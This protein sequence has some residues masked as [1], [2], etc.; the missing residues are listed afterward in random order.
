M[1]STGASASLKFQVEVINSQNKVGLVEY[2]LNEL[3]TNYQYF[4]QQALTTTFETFTLSGKY[5]GL[6]GAAVGYEIYEYKYKNGIESLALLKRGLFQT[7]RDEGVFQEMGVNRNNLGSGYTAGYFRDQKIQLVPGRQQL[8]I[9]CEN[10]GGLRSIYQV[11]GKYPDINY[12]MPAQNQKII[13]DNLA[14]LTPAPS[15]QNIPINYQVALEAF[16]TEQTLP[17]QSKLYTF[18]RT[19]ELTGEVKS[20]YNFTNL[21]VK[22]FTPGLVFENEATEQT[23]KVEAGNRFRIKVNIEI[24]ENVTTKDFD[25]GVIPSIPSLSNL[26]TGVRFIVS[27]SYKDTYFV[28][29]FSRIHP[30][31]WTATE[32]ENKRVPILIKFNRKDLPIPNAW[33]TL[34]LNYTTSLSGHLEP[35]NDTYYCLKNNND[36]MLERSDIK[37]GRNRIQWIL[38]YKDPSGGNS[39]VMSA[40]NSG[41]LGMN[42]DV[43]DYLEEISVTPMKISFS[44]NLTDQYYDQDNLPVLN[45]Q[46]DKSTKVVVKLNGITVKEEQGETENLPNIAFPSEALQE[47]MNELTVS[48]IEG[49]SG[50]TVRKVFSF[51]YDSLK[52]VAAFSSWTFTA[53]E[54]TINDLTVTVNEANYNNACLYYGAD[55]I[56]RYPEVTIIAGNK[57]LLRWANLGIYGI[58]PLP[59]KKVMVMVFDRSGKESVPVYLPLPADLQKPDEEIAR[60]VPLSLPSYNGTP[61][62]AHESNYESKPF[63][64]HTK[65]APRQFLP[66]ESVFGQMG[67]DGDYLKGNIYYQKVTASDGS[68]SDVLGSAV[69]ISG[70]YAI[71][72]APNDDDNGTDS[73][74][75]YIFERDASG[76]WKQKQKL[77]AKDTD[78]NTDSASKANDHFG[79]SVA[80]SGD[81]A[82]VGAPDDDDKGDGS[83]AAYIF[84]RDANG[85][86]QQRQ[87]I[88]ASDGKGASTFYPANPENAI[89]PVASISTRGDA[90]GYSVALSGNI[91]VIGASFDDSSNHHDAGSVYIFERNDSGV[92]QQKQKLTASDGGASYNTVTVTYYLIPNW[93]I[94]TNTVSVSVFYCGDNFGSAVSISGNVVSIGARGDDFYTGSVYVFER[95]ESGVWSQRQKLMANDKA[96]SDYFGNKVAISG[97]LTV[98]G[99]YRDDND[100]GTD[101]GAAYI[102]ERDGSGAWN[103]VQKLIPND[104][105]ASNSIG[106]AGAICGNMGLIATPLDV[107]KGSDAGAVYVFGRGGSGW[108]QQRKITGSDGVATDNFGCAVAISGNVGII[109]VKND[110]NKGADSGSVNFY[111]LSISDQLC[112]PEDKKYLVFKVAK[113]PLMINEKADIDGRIKFES[114]G[115]KQSTTDPEIIEPVNLQELSIDAAKKFTIEGYNLIYYVVEI[116]ELKAKFLAASQTNFPS[117]NAGPG[118]YIYDQGSLRVRYDEPV[119]SHLSGVYVTGALSGTGSSISEILFFDPNY[120]DEDAVTLDPPLNH[121][122][123]DVTFTRLNSAPVSTVNF[124]IRLEDEGLWESGYIE[125]IQKQFLEIRAGD[126]TS[127]LKFVYKGKKLLMYDCDNR[128]YRLVGG[129]TTFIDPVKRW[130]MITLRITKDQ[131]SIEV[132]IDNQTSMKFEDLTVETLTKILAGGTQFYFGPPQE[133]DYNTGFYSIAGAFY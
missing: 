82:I 112:I 25:I 114:L 90:F 65:F 128:L 99:S 86:W 113:D 132:L 11:D 119:A 17:D 105:L 80:I 56:S 72:G 133:L 92:W 88:T 10:P 67:S 93:P 37:Y 29:D 116:A 3:D 95:N 78:P 77:L 38:E 32:R 51:L 103:Q 59:E 84:K 115:Y 2:K 27:K 111:N 16:E 70:N 6:E 130:N 100:R 21:I 5:Y 106:S 28:P 4:N 52:P 42:D 91:A 96:Q 66:K 1:N 53:D 69:A 127:L 102:Y 131:P 71:V 97:N 68:A 49:S 83:G 81:F 118:Y 39:I 85:V 55:I 60:E 107:V 40:S 94:Y 110:D 22:S 26:K 89:D 126:G 75:A 73:G 104:A 124:W 7:S 47:G 43:F 8:W 64:D 62:L 74:S 122:E 58:Y 14:Q 98:V 13:F 50:E 15:V 44:P 63:A 23:I 117:G 31:Q 101:A 19:Y 120:R 24:K 30:D 125:T 45:I 121:S 46:K 57:Y 36:P 61:P 129:L 18:K 48:Y 34:I 109:G 108:S 20:L 12:T 87:K 54:K 76:I 79:S 33:M 123:E 9:Y 35:L 41:R